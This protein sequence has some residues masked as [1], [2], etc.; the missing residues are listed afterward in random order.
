MTTH[1]EVDLREVYDRFFAL[2][3]PPTQ[4]A[5]KAWRYRRKVTSLGWPAVQLI[6]EIVRATRPQRVLDLGSGLTSIVLRELAREIPGMH[7]VTTDTS[8][9]WLLRT[10]L[11]L[12]R[13]GLSDADC[14]MH[15]TFEASELAKERYDFITVDIDNTP[16][17]RALAD[18]LVG[19][20]AE[21][22]GLML[23]DDW[24][25]APYAPTMTTR[26]LDAGLAV[27]PRP[28]TRDEFGRFVA[29]AARHMPHPWEWPD[30]E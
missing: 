27:Q 3:A 1:R 20:L 13:D 16:F 30:D 5:D 24:Q 8:H 7:V 29:L 9:G 28:E 22:D 14:F 21:A 18:K 23:L 12:R 2:G 25:I 6:G 19:W 4:D 15:G 17:R 10:I 26:L 11:E